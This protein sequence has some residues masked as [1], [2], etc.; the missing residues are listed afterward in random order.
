MASKNNH[1]EI[2]RPLGDLFFLASIFTALLINSVAAQTT[3]V[4]AR[5]QKEVVLA[6]DSRGTSATDPQKSTQIC[7]IARCGKMYVGLAGFYKISVNGVSFDAPQIL[8]QSCTEDRS[9]RDQV[10]TFERLASRSLTRFLQEVQ[11]REP[12]YYADQVRQQTGL[13]LVFIGYENNLPFILSRDFILPSTVQEPAGVKM[14]RRN[15]AGAIPAEQ[16]DY[17]FAGH[18]E[19]ITQ[20]AQTHTDFWRNG[21]AEGAKFLVAQ[22][23]AAR[24]LIVGPPID[25]VRIDASG[26]HWI[27][28][29]AQ[30][31]SEK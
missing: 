20:Y 4:A 3:I 26:V 31:E 2:S 15:Q 25:I 1:S 8:A 18:H 10:A 14:R 9:S 21:L 23:I 5:S 17:V 16:I 13:N 7:K 24:P 12:F 6:A 28:R 11:K 29:K 19:E 30:C 22:M 27:Q